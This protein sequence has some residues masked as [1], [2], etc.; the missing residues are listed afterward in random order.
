MFLLGQIF[1]FKL[2]VVKPNIVSLSIYS[3]CNLAEHWYLQTFNFHLKAVE[4]NLC[5]VHW[6][7]QY[8]KIPDF[9]YQHP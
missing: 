3:D 8:I 9:N 4:F 2:L 5:W 1:S 7:D 6:I